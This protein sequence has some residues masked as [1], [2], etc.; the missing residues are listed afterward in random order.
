[1]VKNN[2]QL[3]IGMSSLLCGETPLELAAETAAVRVGSRVVA[4]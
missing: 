4:V 1:M 2:A 3:D